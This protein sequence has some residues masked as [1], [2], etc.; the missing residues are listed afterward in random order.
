M[1]AQSSS[2]FN[3]IKSKKF[4]TFLDYHYSRHK[5]LALLDEV[6]P[7]LDTWIAPQRTKESVESLLVDWHNVTEKLE[8]ETA[9]Q[10]FKE[11]SNRILSLDVLVGA[12]YSSSKDF[13]KVE[14]DISLCMEQIYNAKSTLQKVLSSWAKYTK[15]AQLLKDW[16]HETQK[17]HPKKVPSAT[18]SW[19]NSAY[20]S[21]NEAGTFLIEVSEEQLGLKLSSELKKL[22]KKWV[23]FIKRVKFEETKAKREE[24]KLAKS[25]AE[26]VESY[27]EEATKLLSNSVDIST[28][29][30]KTYIQ[31]L[32]ALHC[33]VTELDF[34]DTPGSSSKADSSIMLLKEKLS[35]ITEKIS[36]AIASSSELLPNVEKMEE[37][38][39]ANTWISES[40]HILKDVELKGCIE[41]PQEKS[42]QILGGKGRSCQEHVATAEANLQILR[43]KIC[44]EPALQQFYTAGLQTRIKQTKDNIQDVVIE[45]DAVLHKTE[46]I[47][48]K[49]DIVMNFEESQKELETYITN[50]VHLLRQKISPEECISRYEDTFGSFDTRTLDKFLKAANQMKSIQSP[51]QKIG[52]EEVSLNLR[53][54]WE[55]VHSEISS[56]VL[57]LKIM[58][59]K[60]KFDEIFL[61]LKKQMEREREFLSSGEKKEHKAMLGQ[62][63]Q[64]LQLIREMCSKVTRPD[65][66]KEAEV[67]IAECEQKKEDLLK[68]A[69][70]VCSKLQSHTASVSTSKARKL[71]LPISESGVK[72]ENG[73]A[74]SS[75]SNGLCFSPEASEALTATAAEMK[76]MHPNAG[77]FAKHVNET[78]LPLQT[79]LQSYNTNKSNLELHLQS[80]KGICDSELP[81]KAQNVVSLQNKLEELQALQIKTNS[82][83]KE[84]EKTSCLVEKLVEDVE[85]TGIAQQR[86]RLNKEWQEYHAVLTSR[87]KSLKSALEV[88]LPIDSEAVVLCESNEQLHKNDT[89]QFTLSNIDS[90]FQE[91]KDVQKSVDD[92]IELCNKLDSSEV[93]TAGNISSE[94]LQMTRNIMLQYR[95]QFEETNQKMQSNETILKKLEDFLSRFRTAQLSL[96]TAAKNVAMDAPELQENR[97]KIEAVQKEISMMKVEAKSLDELMKTV[98]I[99]MQ[100]PES[101]GATSCEKLITD[102]S[103]K[104][105]DVYRCLLSKEEK[106]KQ[107]EL[108]ETFFAKH[109][110]LLKHIGD[111][112][113]QLSKIGLK[114]P[115]I[116]AIHLR[117][118]SLTDLERKL[119]SYT[120]AKECLKEIVDNLKT[121]KEKGEGAEQQYRNVENLWEETRLSLVEGHEDCNKVMELLRDFQTCK[122][123]VTA[124]IQQGEHAVQKQSSY[125]GKD[126]LQRTIAQTEALREKLSGHSAEVDKVNN[127]GKMLQF[128]LSKMKSFQEPPFE[129]EANSLLD[130][131]LDINEKIESYGENLRRG[132]ALWEKSIKSVWNVDK[133]TELQLKRLKE[134]HLTKEEVIQLEVELQTK[135]QIIEEFN[136]K[137]AEIQS[138]LESNDP[139][140]ELQVIKTSVLN[141]MQQIRTQIISKPEDE[142]KTAGLKKDLDS[143]RMQLGAIKSFLNALSVLDDLDVFSTLENMHKQILHQKDN[144]KIFE[145]DTDSPN[146]D[147]DDLKKL[148]NDVMSIYIAKT[149]SFREHYLEILHGHQQKFDDWFSSAQLSKSEWFGPSK[150]KQAMEEKLHQLTVFITSEERKNIEQIKTLLSKVGSH[151]PNEMVVQLNSYIINRETELHKLTSECQMR[152]KGLQDCEILFHRFQEQ[153]SG[154]NKWLICQEGKLQLGEKKKEELENFNQIILGQREAFDSLQQLATSLRELGFTDDEMVTKSC[155]LSTRYLALQIQVGEKLSVTHTS[156]EEDQK[157]NEKLGVSHSIAEDKK[158]KETLGVT[159]TSS[160]DQK[161]KEKLGVSHAPA[162]EDQKFK[163][164]LGVADIPSG[165]QK[166]RQKIGDIHSIT[167]EDQKF[168]EKLGVKQPPAEEDQKFKEKLINT[169]SPAVEDKKFKKKL[170]ITQATSA[171]QKFKEKLDVT[172][173]PAEGQKFEEKLGVAYIPSEHQNFKERIGDNHTS[174]E[175]DQKFKEKLA[176]THTPAE[177]DQKFEQKLGVA[178]I[179][180]EEDQKCNE[181]LGNSHSPAE[182]EQHFKEKLDVTHPPAKEYQKFKEKQD[183]ALVPSEHQIFKETLGDPHAPA[184]KNQKIKE[185]LDVAHVPFEDQEL[186]DKFSFTHSPAEEDQKYKEKLGITQAPFEDQKVKKRLAVTKAPAEEDEKFKETIGVADVVSE[187]QIIKEKLGATHPPAEEDKKFKEKLGVPHIP[188]EDQKFKQIIGVTHAASEDQK[189]KKL[190]ATNKPAEED[191]KFKEKLAVIHAPA[192]DQIFKEKLV[193]GHTSA[194]EN[195]KFKE[196][197]GVICA[198]TEED[199]NCKEKLVDTHS[200]AEEDQKFKEKLSVAHAPSED[201]KFKE[202]LGVTQAPSED[203][204][205]KK[206]VG[207][208][209]APS[210]DQKFKKKLGIIHA[211]S[212]DQKFKEKIGVAYVASE[213]QIIKE[214]LGATHAPAEEDQ[215]FKEKLVVTHAP[216]EDQKFKKLGVPNKPADEDQKFKEKLG[217]THEP[218]EEDQKFEEK[219]AVAHVPSQG[220]KFKETLGVTQTHSEHQKV[221][222]KL[223]VTKVPTKEDQK[224]KEKLGVNHVP[225]EENQKFDEKLAVAHVHSEDQIFKEKLGVSD[226][227]AE[228]D[229]KSKEKLGVTHGP[230]E[231][232]QKFKVKLGVTQPP[233]EKDQKF[234]EKIDVTHSIAGDQKFK[235][236]LDV[237]QAPSED[238]KV[239]KKLSITKAP[240]EEDQKFEEKLDVAHVPS[241]D[242]IFKEKVDVSYAP[243]EDDQ[244][245]KEKL[246]DTHSPAEEDQKFKEKLGVAHA[247]SESQKLQEKLGITQVLSEDQKVKMKLGV[248]KAPAEEDQKFQEKLVVIH[249]PS[250]D[251]KFKKLAVTKEPA[252]EDQRLG[253]AHVPSGDQIFKEKL[254]VSYTPAEDDQKFKVKLGVTQPLAEKDQKFKEKIDV[255][256]STAGEDHKFKEKLGVTQAPSED[257]KVKKKVKKKLGVTKAPAEDDQKFEEKLDVA[258]VPSEDQIFKEKLGVSC[259]PAD[260]GQKFKEMLCVTCAP[261]EDQKFKGSPAGEDQKFKEK[262]GV[263]HAPSESQKFEEK[264][265]VTQVLSEDEKVKMNLGATKA[266]AEEDHKC[267]EKLVVIHATAEDQNFE[268][269]LA[270]AHVPSKDQKFKEKIGVSQAPSENQ[271]VKKMLGVTKAST[272]EDQKFEEKIGDNHALAEEDQ[273]FEEKLGVAHVP[274]KDQKFKEELVTHAPAEEDQKFKEKLGVIQAPSEDQKVKRKLGVTK[275]STKEDQKFEEKLGVAHV[276]SKDQKLKE[277]LGDGQKFKEKLGGIQALSENK[278]V[279]KKV[280]KMLGVI[281]APA[282]EDQIGVTHAPAEEDQKIKE[283]LGVPHEPFEVQK[284]KEEL[285]STHAPAEEDQKLKENLGTL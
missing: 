263:A 63:D 66:R 48:F 19:L 116:H 41:T 156:S 245:F 34:H 143:A 254:G 273:K 135:E 9:F 160:K 257:H 202:K 61:K 27:L 121:Q 102:M 54:R 219:L 4:G 177:E 188:F 155:Q 223:D 33:K 86:T 84:F 251:Q 110:E 73:V 174:A 182:E 243:A 77:D 235:E 186:K 170:G 144:L 1:A 130:R 71:F 53:K 161:Y 69:A 211:P 154:L 195:H 213:D 111:I 25:N 91:L 187:D 16:L 201:Q 279:K 72:I 12:S 40:E 274:S 83:W 276:P 45:L 26:H 280:K 106:K 65:T 272:K 17:Q 118:K 204:K 3:N 266:P 237:T 190:G 206:K 145:R 14:S 28:Q 37:L 5:V 97:L 192:E 134:H 203:Q 140:V 96:A 233:F 249:A 10:T 269:K 285:V 80:S 232:D 198:P 228:D 258:H 128:Q 148:Y 256:H 277:K 212:E 85:K 52:V 124:L 268:E 240:V 79:L 267:Q 252:E 30:L 196:K 216:S 126:N 87:M 255:T 23:K 142:G 246:D 167:E 43:E 49:K 152:I 275:A 191:Q 176:V 194:E 225:A 270:V 217:V 165:D 241:E 104:V 260:D 184:G 75:I 90:I 146:S 159:H 234:K 7:N 100:D 123:T 29:T 132:L 51:H 20:S 119:S 2:G 67:L 136:E 112:Y 168:K 175:E 171:N 89:E 127:I 95:K 101:G 150:T 13:K 113:N 253:V 68:H 99:S 222:K 138:L 62:L 11:I 153:F 55:A 36:G 129:K 164:K 209:K 44:S 46:P 117:I 38:L 22:N 18:L 122:N 218:A 220:H 180:T 226:T 35:E 248:T 151:I 157:F 6:K 283:K 108:Q 60:G 227:P 78:E 242:Q 261:V 205:V 185:K 169:H 284:F 56:Y 214:K 107:E 139:P 93:D 120:P 103:E 271:K 207:V 98:E 39:D 236:K 247:P 179:P 250:E 15:D 229:H 92:Q 183:I 259:E 94:D 278:K 193:V 57:Q 82:Y 231:D 74:D 215:K 173:T 238:Q 64:C 166:F 32:Q 230:A 197:L 8:L 24:Y 81:K 210:E 70:A 125:M 109:G 281:K 31:N 76:V 58:I 239:K 200:P 178:H 149:H 133:W 114:D 21:V 265:D 131:W 147:L 181:K 172:H 162:E 282:E 221:K 59:E 141:K 50:A 158:F 105:E 189:F 137:S 163:K 47:L 264:L 88:L 42:L 244:K 199:Q 115:T 208:T 262:L 224:F